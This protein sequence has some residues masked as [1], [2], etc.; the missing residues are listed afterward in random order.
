[1]LS[2]TTGI[3]KTGALTNMGG[4][5][6]AGIGAPISTVS[7]ISTCAA[8]LTG[9]APTHVIRCRVGAHV[10]PDQRERVIDI[11]NDLHRRDMSKTGCMRTGAMPIHC[12]RGICMVVVNQSGSH[13]TSMSLHSNGHFINLAQRSATVEVSMIF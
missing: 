13:G 7:T 1:M 9:A 6:S 4:P 11:P 8:W 2:K 12:C 3:S 10:R 5:D